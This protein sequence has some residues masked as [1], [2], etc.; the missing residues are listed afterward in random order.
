[1]SP[2]DLVYPT[3]KRPPEGYSTRTVC[4]VLNVSMSWLLGLVARGSLPPPDVYGGRLLWPFSYP[5]V[6][7]AAGMA[8]PGTY[9]GFPPGFDPHAELKRWVRVTKGREVRYAE[10]RK[11]K[12]RAPRR[13]GGAK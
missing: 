11:P 4:E 1:M 12:G 7:R 9:P 6:Y 13:K 8:L 5:A 2:D 10:R 3:T